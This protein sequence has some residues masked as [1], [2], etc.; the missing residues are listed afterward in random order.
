MIERVMGSPAFAALPA[1]VRALHGVGSGRFLGDSQVIRG[2]GLL[3]RLCGLAAGLPAAQPAARAEIQFLA[4][5]QG[6]IWTRVFGTSKMRSS[7]RQR[8][9]LLQEQLGIVQFHF[10][11]LPDANGFDWQ[12]RGVRVFGV[13]LPVSLFKGVLARSFALDGVYRFKVSATLPLVGFIIAYDGWL[14]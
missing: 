12:V 8:Q 2:K 1:A 5:S 4:D 13:P 7:L 6:Q 3:S 11:L 14:E 10:Q 9:D